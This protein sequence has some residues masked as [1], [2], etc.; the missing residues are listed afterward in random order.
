MDVDVCMITIGRTY[1]CCVG[2]VAFAVPQWPYGYVNAISDVRK[3]YRRMYSYHISSSEIIR[4][5]EAE[6][7]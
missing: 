1:I 3:Q 5:Y 2:V 7:M 6:A 4:I